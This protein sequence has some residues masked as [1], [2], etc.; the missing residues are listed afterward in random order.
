MLVLDRHKSHELAEFH[1]YC[2]KHNIILLCLPPHSSHLTQPLNVGCFSVLKRLY[3]RQIELFIK[4]YINHITKVEFFLAFH[5]AYK[6]S[7]TV[8]NAKAGFHGAGLVLY[9]PESV[10][11]KLDVKLQTPTPTAPPSAGASPWVSQTPHNAAEA[12]SQSTL[13][14]DYIVQH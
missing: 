5:T 3:R 7:I 2:Y 4:A 1:K 12:L 13:V 14:K 11:S 10:I 6:E 9:N 8:Q